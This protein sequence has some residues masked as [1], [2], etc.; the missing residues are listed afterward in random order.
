MDR[1]AC[2]LLIAALVVP[3]PQ[4]AAASPASVASP[5]PAVTVALGEAVI[6]SRAKPGDA[7]H[8]TTIASAD[9]RI[10]V[11]VHGTGRVAIVDRARKNSIPA[12]VKLQ[13]DPLATP[14]GTYGL[15]GDAEDGTLYMAGGANRTRTGFTLIPDIGM[16]LSIRNMFQTGKDLELPAGTPL[17]LHVG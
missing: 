4:P 8:Y 11:G 6:A 5:C 12:D 3:A 7:F 15:R 16:M 13:F 14:H 1:R 2:T 9:P 17:C 10:P